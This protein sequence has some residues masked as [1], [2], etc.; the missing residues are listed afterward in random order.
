MS[1]TVNI[2][3]EIIGGTYNDGKSIEESGIEILKS[4]LAGRCRTDSRIK[5]P[6]VGADSRVT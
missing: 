4:S 5:R 6:G 3:K 2:F 1:K